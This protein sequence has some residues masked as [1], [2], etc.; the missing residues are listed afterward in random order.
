MEGEL[1]EKALD[2]AEKILEKYEK[3]LESRS[4]KGREDLM[5]TLVLEL[6][7]NEG[8]LSAEVEVDMY[9]RG[10]SFKAKEKVAQLID[11]ARKAV[12]ELA[13]ELDAEER[14]SRLPIGK[15]ANRDN[16]A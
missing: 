11:E 15:E 8:K 7:E 13:S 2:K 14:D 4:K 10:S 1:S 16:D 6:K 5:L 9:S 12:E 3:V